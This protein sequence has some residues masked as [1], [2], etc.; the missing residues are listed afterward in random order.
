[1]DMDQGKKKKGPGSFHLICFLSVVFLLL[2]G[3][4]TLVWCTPDQ[5]YSA[6]ERRMLSKRPK[7]NKKNILNGKFQRKYEVYLSEQFPAREQARA[8][9]TKLERLLGSRDAGGVYFG[10]DGY[11]LEKY[12]EQDFDWEKIKKNLDR[13]SIFLGKYPN[14]RVMF[15]PSKSGILTSKLPPFAVESGEG[16]FW[17]LVNQK[18][19]GDRQIKVIQALQAHEN[20]YIYYRSDHHWTTF[21]AY[22]AYQEWAKAM[23]VRCLSQ[24][25]F[26]VTS[27]TDK[28]LGTTYAKVRTKTQPDQIHLY[29]E[30]NENHLKLDYN[31]GEFQSDSF[32]DR[33]KLKGDDPYQ[34]FMGGNQPI[35]DIYVESGQ[36]K[37]LQLKNKDGSGKTLLLVKDSFGNCFAPFLANH[38][39][40]M[41]V[42]DLRHVN[43]PVGKLLK[44]YPADDILILYNSIQFMEDMDISKIK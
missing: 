5:I 15:V 44:I 14:A 26:L 32:Y 38:Y 11:L 19:A 34:V 1:M 40:R 18:I 6:Q 36:S 3:S 2:A 13:V 17:G 31:G 33:S 4:I 30:K 28:F 43:I 35:V 20:E 29:Q 39:E 12:S 16:R 10:K 24:E 37:D 8:L 42:I 25:D 27:V 7:L 9:K 21:G 23:E 22:L 41:I